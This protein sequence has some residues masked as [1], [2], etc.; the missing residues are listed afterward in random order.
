MGRCPMPFSCLSREQRALVLTEISDCSQRPGLQQP[1]L[2][3]VVELMTKTL[4][5]QHTERKGCSLD[6]PPTVAAERKH[7]SE[8]A[9]KQKAIV[10]QWHRS[11]ILAT[12]QAEIGLLEP[13]SSRPA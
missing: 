3:P 6:F 10:V 1:Q 7:R 2:S 8:R 12:W 5:F 4:M 9:I 13:M 11:V